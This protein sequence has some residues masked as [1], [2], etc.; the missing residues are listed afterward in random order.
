MGSC[1]SFV[2]YWLHAGAVRVNKEKMSKS[3]GNFITI[4]EL[5]DKYQ[6]EVIRFNMMLTHYR[7]KSI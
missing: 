2:N 4:N 1:G 5:K 3:L 7:T 6:G